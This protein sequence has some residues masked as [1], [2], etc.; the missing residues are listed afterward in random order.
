[1][2]D[3]QLRVLLLLEGYYI[4]TSTL[5]VEYVAKKI[6]AEHFAQRV[7]GLSKAYEQKLKPRDG[8]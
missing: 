3:E 6:D 8:R 2:T 4:A 7:V 5:A 1:M